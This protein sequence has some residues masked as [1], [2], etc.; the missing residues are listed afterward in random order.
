MNELE[1][2]KIV[3]NRIISHLNPVPA[4]AA[5]ELLQQPLQDLE[6]ILSKLADTREQE[7]VE[8]EA[9]A[10]IREAQAERASDGAWGAALV[11]VSLNGKYLTDSESNRQMLESLLQPHEQPSEAIYKTLALQFASK[12]SWHTPQPKPT[13]ED[14]RAAFEL[15]VREHSL[16]SVEANFNLF[17]EGASVEHFAGASGIERSQ[18]ADEQAIARQ[19][20][21]IHSATPQQLKQEAA[22]E[23]QQN[24]VAAQREEATRQHQFVLSQQQGNYPPLPA[25]MAETGE[26]I[27][28]KFVRRLSTINYPLFRAWVK[29]YG[30]GNLNSRLRGEN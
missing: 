6:A 28:A 9:L 5:N 22:W 30:V 18:Y 20:F 29:K 2:K 11:R 24:R 3:V 10:R 25:T 23:S 1:T 19:H 21:L 7:Q 13:K 17:K 4:G 26:V 16:S 27:D 15:F 8:E 12:F 14:Q